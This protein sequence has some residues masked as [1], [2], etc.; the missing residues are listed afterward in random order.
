MIARQ[1]IVVDAS[2]SMLGSKNWDIS[3]ERLSEDKKVKLEKN[4]KKDALF[5]YEMLKSGKVEGILQDSGKPYTPLQWINKEVPDISYVGDGIDGLNKCWPGDIVTDGNHMGI[6]T[7]P[8]KTINIS[9]KTNTIVEDNW[10]WRKK[11]F[12]KVKIFRYEP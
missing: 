4:E 1:T 5:I 2:K 10:G 3:S 9:E 12:P 7:A 8:Q 11:D 6:I